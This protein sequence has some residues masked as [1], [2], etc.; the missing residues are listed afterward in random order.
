MLLSGDA[1]IGKSRLTAAMLERLAN[2][3]YARMRYFCSPQHTDSALYPFIRQMERAA[4]LLQDAPPRAK[5]DKLDALLQQTSISHQD[6]TLF[7]EMLSLPND[8]RYPVLDLA[9]QQRRQGTLEALTGQIA[10]LASEQAVLIIFEDVHW[11][12]PTSLEALNRTMDR[13]RS[14]PVL[15]IM[16]FRPEFRSAW[17]ELSNVTSVTLNR[18]RESEATAIVARLDGN[19]ELPAKVMAEIVQRT[20]GI[21]LFVEEMTKAVLEA[22]S[23]SK[24]QRAL[25]AAPSAVLTV[26]ASLQASLMARLDRLGPA[27]EVAQI[28]AA[29]GREFSHRV[30]ALVARMQEVALNAALDRLIHADLL[31]QQGRPPNSSYLFKHA[32]VQDAAYGTLLREPRRA[33]HARIV[34]TLENHFADSTEAHPEVLA[35]H[36]FEARFTE[37]AASLWGKAGLRSLERSAMVEAAEQLTRALAQI[38]ALAGTPN[39]RREQI[40]LQVALITAF[41]QVKGHAAPET[42]AAAERASLLIE[43]AEALGEPPDDPLLLFSILH[44]FWVAS[45]ASFQSETM[46]ELAAQFLTLAEKQ[47]GTVPLMVGH[48]LMG[49]SLMFTGKIADARSHYNKAVDL[50]DPA[51]FRILSTRFGQDAGV[52][53]LCYRSYNLW[54]LGYP[55]AAI[56]DA[57]QAIRNARELEHGTTLLLALTY[58]SITH[59]RC[60]NYTIANARLEEA[61]ALANEKGAMFWK[62]GAMFVQGEIFTKAGKS[63]EAITAIESSLAVWRSTGT[64]MF[65]PFYLASLSKAHADLGEFDSALHHLAEAMALLETTNESWCEAEV[66]RIAGEIALLS[67]DANAAKA[68]GFFERAIAVSQEQ[69][70]KSWELRAAVSMARLRRDQGKIPEAQDLLRVTLGWFKEGFNTADLREA[71][72]LL[73]TLTSH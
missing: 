36:C 33:I 4:G 53:N 6:A 20:D 11:I 44:G 47:N 37:K 5:L 65:L 52:A 73:E 25:D 72:V 62:A 70:A 23:G 2:E 38:A 45:H 14:L 41:M 3:S 49:S 30:L 59:G 15:L 56:A 16:T 19:R 71:N 51:A 1:G 34:E 66:Y 67:N 28:G 8:G 68:E 55:A 48:R 31:S 64:K 40:K 17:A 69:R 7:A 12:D 39:L 50:Y 63:S 61:V 32:L 60:G 13:V 35:R 54:L 42:K 9:P 57:E 27:K 43:Q 22:E 18:L 26:P 24:G 10:E 58:T 29:I 21:P 46:R